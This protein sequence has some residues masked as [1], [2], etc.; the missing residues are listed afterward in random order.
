MD[1]PSHKSLFG[2]QLYLSFHVIHDLHSTLAKISRMLAISNLGNSE[3]FTKDSALF[4]FVLIVLCEL[5]Y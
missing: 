1:P 5:I 2:S 4:S 3:S